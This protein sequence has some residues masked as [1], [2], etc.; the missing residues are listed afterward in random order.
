MLNYYE[1]ICGKDQNIAK[2]TTD[3]R[4]CIYTEGVG[5]PDRKKPFEIGNE[6]FV[7]FYL[8][9]QTI[10]FLSRRIV[11]L[12]PTFFLD[13]GKCEFPTGS[14]GFVLYLSMTFPLFLTGDTRSEGATARLAA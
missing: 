6:A 3:P 9:G 2:C 7:V 4:N 5:F 11:I 14:P 13:R 1:A 10:R 12:I 8:C